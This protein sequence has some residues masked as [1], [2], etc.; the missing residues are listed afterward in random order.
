M[1]N[2]ENHPLKLIVFT[3]SF[4]FLISCTLKK[5]SLLIPEDE[6]I[7]IAAELQL[8]RA[9]LQVTK[10]TIAFMTLNDALLNKYGYRAT[11]FDSSHGFYEKD[12]DAQ[13]KRYR[14]VREY[15]RYLEQGPLKMVN[16]V[17]MLDID[18]TYKSERSFSE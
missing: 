5:S 8:S 18:S 14:R 4:V 7:K 3:M 2:S 11:Q 16:P 17:L 1:A 6:Y 15:I 10:D 13:L 9:Y 12:Y